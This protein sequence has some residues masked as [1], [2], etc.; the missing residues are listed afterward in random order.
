MT[1]CAVPVPNPETA[2]EAEER[3]TPWETLGAAYPS[4]RP[5]Y[6]EEQSVFGRDGLG[7]L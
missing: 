2:T 7:G 6:D 5:W 1:V 3:E 4:R